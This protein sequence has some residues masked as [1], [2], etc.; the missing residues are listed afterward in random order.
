MGPGLPH[1]HVCRIPCPLVSSGRLTDPERMG[2]PSPIQA[3]VW[4]PVPLAF[5]R[6]PLGTVSFELWVSH[7]R[8]HSG[9]PVAWLW[10]VP[11]RGAG[12]CC[13]ESPKECRQAAGRPER[14]VPRVCSS[15]NPRASHPFRG[16]PGALFVFSP[17]VGG[18]RSPL[19]HLRGQSLAE[20]RGRDG[21]GSPC[22]SPAWL[23]WR[24]LLRWVLRSE[25]GSMFG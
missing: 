24:R 5:S 21:P 2:L 14:S 13:W 4:M 6:C 25:S 8:C 19:R 17:G 1:P 23:G 18:E 15:P 3:Q 16:I 7:G 10:G 20:V 12:G 11:C 9:Q 22:V